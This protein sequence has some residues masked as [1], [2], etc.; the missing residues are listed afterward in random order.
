MRSVSLGSLSN[1]REGGWVLTSWGHQ[2]SSRLLTFTGRL[3]G[4]SG[5]VISQLPQ[6]G[7]MPLCWPLALPNLFPT[8]S[9]SALLKT[10]ISPR[11]PR[12]SLLGAPVT[13]RD[14]RLHT[15]LQAHVAPRPHSR[16]LLLTLQGP[17][18]RLSFC[19]SN[20]AR[21]GSINE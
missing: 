11:E 18:S 14:P 15:S 2:T 10:C 16:H 7:P 8:H 5:D 21:V 20:I 9:Q 3:A 1:S 19:F 13:V 4:P 17:V 12:E 6:P